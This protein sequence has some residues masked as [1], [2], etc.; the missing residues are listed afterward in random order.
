[1][2]DSKDKLDVFSRSI[3]VP[4]EAFKQSLSMNVSVPFAAVFRF[5]NMTKVRK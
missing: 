2:V 3:A 1:M 4:E 5:L